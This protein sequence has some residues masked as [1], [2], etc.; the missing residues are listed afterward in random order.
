MNY[1]LVGIKGSGMAGIA[2]I[3]SD[4]GHYV[5]GSDTNNFVFTEERLKEKGILILGFNEV[6]YDTIDVV[7]V[8]HSF[9]PW[10]SEV[11]EAHKRSIPVIEYNEFLATWVNHSPSIAI[12]GS[13]G[14]TTTTGYVVKALQATKKITY[15]IGDGTA[16]AQPQSDYFV[17]EACE[18]RRHFL[19]YHPSIAVILNVD[20]DHTDYFESMEDYR[21]AF[22]QF[23]SQV[24]NLIIL[25]SD[26][27]ETQKINYPKGKTKTFGI[28]SN[29][30]LK[31]DKIE[32]KKEG[33]FFH[34]SY[35]QQLLGTM[36]I[37]FFGEAMIYN[38]LATILISLSSG[39]T[40][41][42]TIFGMNQFSG[43]KRRY[44]ETLSGDDVIIDDYAHHPSQIRAVIERVRLQFPSRILVAIY[45]PDRYSRLWS[46]VRDIANALDLAD[47]AFILPFPVTAKNDTTHEFDATI[48]SRFNPRIGLLGA[49]ESWMTIEKLPS[50]VIF[51]FM[52]SKDMS[53]AKSHLMSLRNKLFDKDR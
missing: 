30:D 19:H 37:P 31:A 51:L 52:S 39:Q 50:P 35:H 17:F 9:F 27:P 21:S 38:A 28:H 53:E 8:G 10:H 41:D 25:N 48:L 7:I 16:Q 15:L 1:H 18:Y 33:T 43:T 5:Q 3:L 46:F 47:H 22:Q 36:M 44:Q 42:E 45:Q 40:W 4:Q 34:V 23:I 14:K 20:L 11:E 26:D 24:K 32:I 6:K 49:A 29:A 2:Q 12:A 13:H